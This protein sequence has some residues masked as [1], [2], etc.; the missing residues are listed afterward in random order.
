MD[1]DIQTP[2]ESEDDDD[3]YFDEN[4]SNEE[5]LVADNNPNLNV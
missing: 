3:D 1:E 4:H 2:I 5:D